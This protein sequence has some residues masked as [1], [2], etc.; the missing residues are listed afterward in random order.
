MIKCKIKLKFYRFNNKPIKYGFGGCLNAICKLLMK[1]G[2]ELPQKLKDQIAI[3][4]N[5]EE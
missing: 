3:S 4:L 5:L 2:T 1:L